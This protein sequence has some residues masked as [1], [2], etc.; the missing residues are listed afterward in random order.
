MPQKNQTLVSEIVLLGFQNLH[1]IKIP[2][3]S[4]F[5]LIYIMTVWENVLIIVLVSSSR[6][7]ESPM[8]FFLQQLSLSDL[9]GSTVIVPTLLQTVLNGDI[10]VSLVGCISQWYFF[11][12]SDSFQCVLL[13]VMSYDRYVAIC[14]PLRYSSIMSHRVCFIL[15]LTPWALGFGLAVITVNLMGTLQFC[16]QNTINHFFCDFVPLLEL[17]CSD[18]F[19]LKIEAFFLSVPMIFVPFILITVSYVCIAHAILKIVSNT[20]RQKA[21]ST[22]SSHLAVVSIFYGT[23]IAIY[24]VPPRKE[25]ETI[26]KVLSLL[27]T[28]GIPLVN[29]LIYSLRSKDIKE[30]LKMI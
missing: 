22:C 19:L 11:S 18:T 14:I 8:Y 20:G 24:V 13:A 21:F 23:I 3:F 10:R 6:N 2:L 26:S 25:S 1:N 9:L 30:A 12:A 17:S 7:L 28:V 27:Y 29:P 15:I 16:N 5:L 4:L